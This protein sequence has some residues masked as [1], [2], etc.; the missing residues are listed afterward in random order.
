MGISGPWADSPDIIALYKFKN[1]WVLTQWAL[2]PLGMT[3]LILLPCRQLKTFLGF[4]SMGLI[5]PRSKSLNV[6]EFHAFKNCKGLT[7]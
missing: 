7:L 1:V 5:A 2:V 4:N 3:L 6:I